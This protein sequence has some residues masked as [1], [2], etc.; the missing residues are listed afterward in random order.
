[1]LLTIS[2]VQVSDKGCWL[3][4][5]SKLVIKVTCHVHEIDKGCWLSFVS[6]RV[7]KDAG[8]QLCQSES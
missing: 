3:Y 2:S 1:M 4:I 5:V 6:K 8:Y 7:I